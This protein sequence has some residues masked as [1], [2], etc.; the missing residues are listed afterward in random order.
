MWAE[1]GARG[2]NYHDND[3][4]PIDATLAEQDKIVA[5]FSRPCGDIYLPTTGTMLGFIETLDHAEMV[6]VNPEVAHEHVE[7][8]L[9]VRLCFLGCL[10]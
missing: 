1:A 8:L 7:L 10:L 3:L 5:E 9:G 4:V 6:G 2:A